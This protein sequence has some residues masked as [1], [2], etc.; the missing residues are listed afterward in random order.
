MRLKSRFLQLF[1]FVSFSVFGQ[2]LDVASLREAIKKAPEDTS[3]VRLLNDLAWE[4]KS[5]FPDEALILS[6]ESNELA[7]KLGDRKGRSRSYK[8]SGVV[9]LI[10]G[11]HSNALNN[12]FDALKIDEA[13]GDHEGMASAELNIGTI[14]KN[15]EHYAEA[16]MYYMRAISRLREITNNTIKASIYNNL[17]IVYMKMEDYDKALEYFNMSMELKEGEDDKLGL[18]NTYNNVGVIYLNKGNISEARAFYDK[19]LKIRERLGDRMGL[20]TSY[21]NIGE[22]WALE[23]KYS[24]AYAYINK[25]LEIARGIGSKKVLEE[26]YEVLANAYAMD[27]KYDKA[28]E[29]H[30]LYAAMRDTLVNEESNRQMAMAQSQYESRVQ[31]QEIALQKNELELK[32]AALEKKDSEVKTL[33]AYILGVVVLF[34]A[35]VLLVFYLR[36]KRQKENIVLEKQMLELERQAL[37]LQMNPHFIFNCLNSISNFISQN[38]KAAAKRYLARFARLMRLIL[39]NS[40]DQ[41]V[42][43]ESEIEMLNYYLE[44]EQLR[45]NNKFEYEINVDEKLDPSFVSIPPMLIQPYVENAILHG[46]SPKEGSGNIKLYFKKKKGSLV[47]EIEDDGIGR[48]RSMEL[49]SK[50][51]KEHKSIAMDVTKQRLAMLD[52]DGEKAAIKIEDLENNLKESIGTRVSFSIPLLKT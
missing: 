6:Q 27:G 24:L 33:Q 23:G 36:V 51:R 14:Y 48:E 16:L 29:Y 18:A 25:G 11:N 41:F 50:M 28:F 21:Y 15:Q 47:C 19:A 34:F 37:S 1:I 4:L 52:V 12:L 45:F 43:L 3:K 44:L 32:N 49:K 10:Q 26:A 22:S 20:A 38:E 8:C 31:E 5:S 35:G 13:L 42:S 39:E 46:I 17:G 7:K 30:K 2:T 40:R 9:H